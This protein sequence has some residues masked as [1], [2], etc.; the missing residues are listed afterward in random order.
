MF[1]Y[2]C[3][4]GG[5]SCRTLGTSSTEISILKMTSVYHEVLTTA[6]RSHEKDILK[7]KELSQLRPLLVFD[8]K[9]HHILSVH[10]THLL[11]PERCHFFDSSKEMLLI[12]Y[13]L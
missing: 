5:L 3:G 8:I 2:F 12:L 10:I 9:R 7:Q 13:R 6:L 11:T 4:Y 1:I